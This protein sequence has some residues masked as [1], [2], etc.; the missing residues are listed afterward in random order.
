[1]SVQEHVTLR[2]VI[3]PSGYPMPEEA[4]TNKLL[5]DLG[6]TVVSAATADEALGLL[7][8]DPTDILVID[9]TDSP[10]NRNLIDRL[11]ELPTGRRPKELAIFSERSEERFRKLKAIIAPSH[12][13][14]FLKPLHM[15][16]LLNVLRRLDPASSATSAA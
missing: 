16:G 6:H 1:M 13:H 4:P 2:A 11:G 8:N 7:K 5:S 14:V 15:H 12:V 9:V 10:E 3:L